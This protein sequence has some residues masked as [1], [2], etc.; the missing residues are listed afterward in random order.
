[1]FYFT[2]KYFFLNM[3]ERFSESYQSEIVESAI[4]SL[5]GTNKSCIQINFPIMQLVDKKQYQGNTSTMTVDIHCSMS[6]THIE[7]Y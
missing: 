5:N 3:Q 4:F 2:K 1:M 6:D 7:I